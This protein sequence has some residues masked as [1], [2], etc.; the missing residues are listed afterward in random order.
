MWF[1]LY[2]SLSLFFFSGFLTSFW[3]HAM[4]ARTFCCAYSYHVS[5]SY[6]SL[7]GFRHA[8]TLIHLLGVCLS[9]DPWG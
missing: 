7:P 8:R 9:G 3:E 1:V 2:E 6:F 4:H 5:A